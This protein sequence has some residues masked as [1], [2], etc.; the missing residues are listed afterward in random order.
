MRLST[1]WLPLVLTACPAPEEGDDTGSPD[2]DSGETD[3]T[4]VDD[5]APPGPFGELVASAAAGA[6]TVELRA[7]GE[8]QTGL[9]TV[10]YRV[11]DAEDAPVNGLS[12]TH[13]PLMV[14]GSGSSH[15]CPYTQP[16]ALGDGQYASELVYQMPSSEMDAWTHTVTIGGDTPMEA[17]F[18][19]LPVAE[20]GRVKMLT[21]GEAR[22]IVSL[23][24]DDAPMMRENPFILTVH[25]R[26]SMMM[27]PP[28]ADLDVTV[29]PWMPAMDHGSEGN[30][31]PVY[32]ADGRYEGLAYFSMMGTWELRFALS[33][34]GTVVAE[35]VFEVT[36]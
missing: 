10:V 22:W 14:M 1:L 2:T 35:P 32:A 27:F 13:A 25:R 28:V 21:V 4:S 20:S 34:G 23:A 19:S 3:D 18:T 6:Y 33:Q 29:T 12:L 31:D 30:V 11:L 7:E 15:A 5:T 16:V 8:L 26:E 17:D 24:F 9:N 36:F